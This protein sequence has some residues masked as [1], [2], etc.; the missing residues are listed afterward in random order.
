MLTKPRSAI[1]AKIVLSTSITHVDVILLSLTLQCDTICVIDCNI[2]RMQNTDKIQRLAEARQ[3]LANSGKTT[4]ELGRERIHLALDWVYRWGWS[5]PSTIDLLSGAQ[6][7]GLSAKLVKSGLMVETKTAAGSI[8]EDIPAKIVTLSD[9][10]IAEV[11]RFRENLLDYNTNP[12][13]VNQALLRHDL[14]AQKATIKNLNSGAIQD[15][16]TPREL[17]EKSERQLKQPDVLWNVSES[18]TM[19]VEIEL[20]AKFERKLDDFVLGIIL[21]LKASHEKPAR[22]NSCA[23]ISDSDAI[24][25]RYKAAFDP[26]KKVHAWKK[27]AQ[28]KWHID[29]QYDVPEWVRGKMQWLKID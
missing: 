21:S 25:K 4:R 11:E 23:I 9:T 17:S 10:G 22:F 12:Y 26:G 7:R 3:A 14:L 6:R 16:K 29:R 27:D 8:V 5:S 13:K 20:T 15:F 18:R 28:S 24:L 19:A 2:E 1:G